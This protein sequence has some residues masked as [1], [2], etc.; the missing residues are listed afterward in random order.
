MPFI[1]F[2]QL[3]R[4]AQDQNH[5]VQSDL[6]QLNWIAHALSD[7]GHS[8]EINED[9]FLNATEAR[10]WAVADGM[11]GLAR[12]DYASGLV[13]DSLVYFNR[14][15]NLANN[16]RDIETR[17][18]QAHDKCRH[19]FEGER[20]GSTVAALYI[21]GQYAFFLWAGDSRIYRLRGGELTQLSVD[22]TVAQEKIAKGELSERRAALHPSAHVLTRAVGVHQTLHLDLDYA[23]IMAGDR[24]LL[25]SDGLY[26]SLSFDNMHALLGAGSTES[27]INALVENALQEGG[28]DNITAVVVDAELSG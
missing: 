9:A 19:S 28:K 5:S 16:I 13:V 6:A 1:D 11:G 15:T 24:Y 14:S 20:V 23:T 12:G 17:L 21:H 2:Q 8:M 7:L 22:H 10:L 25:C 27:V 26:N 3:E 4:L 18:R